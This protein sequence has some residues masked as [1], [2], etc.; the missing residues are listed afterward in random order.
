MSK[1]APEHLAA[2]CAIAVMA[3]ASIAGV[4]KTR[5]IPPLSADEAAALNTAFLRDATD[6]LAAAARF[7]SVNG[8]LAYAPARSRAFFEG[9]LPHDIQLI[10]TTEPDLGACLFH[11]ASYLLAAG[12]G[13]ACL[14]N[15]D[16]PTLPVAYLVTAATLLAAPGDRVVI[17]PAAD[18]GYYLLGLKRAHRGLFEGVAWS[19]EHVFRETLERAD[20]LGVAVVVLPTWYDV[21]DADALALL[22]PQLSGE[23]APEHLGAVPSAAQHTRRYLQS[24]LESA[25]L[26]HRLR[27]KGRSS[28]VA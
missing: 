2:T 3:K 24:L 20:A 22:I 28:R 14:V 26:A 18:G 27:R 12:Y 21:D 1:Q 4:T 5:L 17:G 13:S 6:N 19:T 25:G 7:A 11:A 9:I 15:S 16:S 10:E 8:F 23:P